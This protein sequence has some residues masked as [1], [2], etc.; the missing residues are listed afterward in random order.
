MRPRKTDNRDLPPGMYRRKRSSKSKKH[1]NKVWISY[2]YLDKSG[3]PIPLGTD[4]SLARL[5]WAELEAKEKPKDL[6]TMSA[7]F[8]RYERDIIPKKAPR[9]QK[10]NL[11]ELR[12]L[13]PYFE[14]APIDGITPSQIAQ[15][16]DARSAKVR[17]NREIATLSHVFNMA[18]EWGLTI[19]ENPCQGIRKNKEVPRDF[20][21]N[22][23]I[24]KAVYAKA[25]D[26]LKVAMDLAYLTGQRP[27]DVLVMRRDDIEDNVLGVKQKKTHKKLRIMLE[28]D[29]AESDLGALIRAILIR[30]E[31]HNSPYLILTSGGLR[32]TAPMLRRRW[33]DAREEAVK[34]AIDSGDQVLAGRIGQFQFRDI[35]PKAASEITDIEHASLL[36]GHTKGDIT[37]RVY[38]RV[39]ALAKPTK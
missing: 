26:E 9:T 13:R 18:R 1:P 37:E 32:V 33:D 5:K 8:D 34:E 38:R 28:V 14:K 15:Y 30:N 12:Q 22:D 20:Y 6:L 35:R 23:A 3:K 19:R 31:P 29:G 25:A 4:L 39:G 21:A 17:A 27:A 2:I 36:L 10:D 7:I 11:A 24:W 16:R